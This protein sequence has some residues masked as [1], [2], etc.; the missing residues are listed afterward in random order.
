MHRNK[1]AIVF[2]VTAGQ[3]AH[4]QNNSDV[5]IIIMGILINPSPAS[6]VQ[7]TEPAWGAAKKS[8]IVIYPKAQPAKMSPGSLKS[9]MG[10]VI[11]FHK[12]MP[13]RAFF[14]SLC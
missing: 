5:I 4:Q 7:R 2:L 6:P 3:I 10:T 1:A 9:K 12:K 13:K 11:I 8:L 14:Y